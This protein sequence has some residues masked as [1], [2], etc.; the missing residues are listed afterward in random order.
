VSTLLFLGQWAL[1]RFLVMIWKDLVLLYL[2]GKGKYLLTCRLL[3][4]AGARLQPFLMSS[5]YHFWL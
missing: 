5:H 4:E 3:S 1:W 2:A